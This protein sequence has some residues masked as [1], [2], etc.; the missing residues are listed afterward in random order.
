M[1]YYGGYSMA[2]KS[3]K[4]YLF[5]VLALA[6]I[7]VLGGFGGLIFDRYVVPPLSAFPVVAH[8]DFFKKLTER[9]TVINKT[10]QVVIRE[11]DTIEKV[12]SQPAT[13][14]VDIVLLPSENKTVKTE[15]VPTTGVLLTNDGLMVTYSEKPFGNGDLRY[16]ALLFDGSDHAMTFVGYDP[17]TNL[18][19][20]RLS[21]VTNT[22]AIALANS[23][24]ARIGKKLI[25]LGSGLEQYQNRLAVNTLG[26]I[27]HTFNLSGK[28][29]ASSEKWEGVFET[30]LATSENF[31]GG[32]AVSYDSEMVGLVGTLVID[33]K[34]Y[35]FLIPSNAVRESFDRAV[36]GTL[37]TRPIL[38]VYYLSITKA[39]FLEQGLARDQGVLIYSP[40][41]K[42]G[43]AVLADSPAMRA[44]LQAGDI[45]EKVNDTEITFDNPFP[46]II[47]SFSK[48]DTI[49]V[50][51]VRGG[52][53]RTISVTL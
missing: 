38:G 29:V 46:E 47:G 52:Q 24:D 27:D 30:D 2:Q 40:S 51:I 10:E 12:I 33:N 20:F 9:V 48:G 50:L 25:A 53:E 37:A 34:I 16:T 18:S 3:I 17:L 4:K 15:V 28:T 19:F 14:V 5:I 1:C 23:D 44:G 31:V 35:V 8:S 43:L 49:N 11:D 36:A 13:A 7:F 45:I 21:D 6:G 26:F 41:G 42:T 39:L 22:P 32:P